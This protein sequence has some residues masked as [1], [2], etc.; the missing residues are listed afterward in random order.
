MKQLDEQ[1]C[2]NL[3][4]NTFAPECSQLERDWGWS[5]SSLKLAYFNRNLESDLIRLMFNAVDNTNNLDNLFSEKSTHLMKRALD[6]YVGYYSD[7]HGPN[8]SDIFQKLKVV[9]ELQKILL[10][11][12]QQSVLLRLRDF[13]QTL[14]QDQI[15][16]K[17]RHKCRDTYVGTLSFIISLPFS[18]YD[19]WHGKRNFMSPA[20]GKIVKHELIDLADKIDNQQPKHNI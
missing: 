10:T 3:G 14:V 9:S 13:K 5:Y 7:Y 1:L 4:L 20:T 6:F 11:N 2:V 18:L 19:L 12:S 16:D 17:N 15:L 8:V